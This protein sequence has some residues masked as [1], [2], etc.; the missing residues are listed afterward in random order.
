M[1]FIAISGS[2]RKGSFNTMLMR[3]A[4]GLAPEGVTIQPETL[5]GIPL[6]NGD[7]EEATGLPPRVADL[8][9]AIAQ[10]DGVIL[11]TPEYN[12]SV[13]GVLKN[14][15]DWLSR[16]P[17]DVPRVWRHKPVALAGATP[18]GF[19]TAMSQVHWLPSLRNIGAV[20]YFGAKVHVAKAMTVFD[21]NGNLTDGAVEKH[22]KAF[23][24]GFAEF[25]MK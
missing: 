20:P 25:C 9:E 7:D 18:G 10:A 17:Q 16:P 23:L 4:V 12:S 21:E 1:R 22:L 15:M 14:A 3:A 19:G 5:H 6:Y 13:P 11:F 24:E 8:K 2:L